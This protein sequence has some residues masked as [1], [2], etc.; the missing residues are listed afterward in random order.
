MLLQRNFNLEGVMQISNNLSHKNRTGFLT[1]LF[2]WYEHRQNFNCLWFLLIFWAYFSIFLINPVSYKTSFQWIPFLLKLATTEFSFSQW[3]NLIG[4][5]SKTAIENLVDSL[6]SHFKASLLK[7]C[8]HLFWM[9][10][11]SIHWGFK[12]CHIKPY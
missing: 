9:K 2:F 4:K 5:G 6:C 8:C 10:M 3:R 12:P 7:V 11:S 1:R